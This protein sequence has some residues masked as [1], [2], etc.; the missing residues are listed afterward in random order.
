MTEFEY[1]IRTSAAR[2]RFWTVH[3]RLNEASGSE[4]RAAVCMTGTK[5]RDSAALPDPS[6]NLTYFSQIITGSKKFIFLFGT[7]PV[8]SYT[9]Q[10]SYLPEFNVAF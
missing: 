7:L 1:N 10:V 3:R 8:R 9:T 6:T 2:R 4:H 5:F